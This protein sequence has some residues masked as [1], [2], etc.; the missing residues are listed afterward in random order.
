MKIVISQPLVKATIVTCNHI[1]NALATTLQ[2]PELMAV[3]KLSLGSKPKT[4]SRKYFT[5]HFDPKK[6]IEMDIYD[7]FIID[8]LTEV[9][10]LTPPLA[11]MCKYASIFEAKLK[12][13]TAAF[14]KKWGTPKK[15]PMLKIVPNVEGTPRE[16]AE[17]KP[18]SN[19]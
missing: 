12:E 16:H 17:N 4:V 11:Q 19:Q 2:K 10:K 3:V 13:A 14:D 9:R 1:S 18:P 6:G 7:D 15:V 8:G 5:A